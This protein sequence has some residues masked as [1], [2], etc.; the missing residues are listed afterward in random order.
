MDGPG[1]SPEIGPLCSFVPHGKGREDIPGGGNGTDE[2]LVLGHRGA[3]G[4]K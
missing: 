2:S 1:G 3:E 4:R